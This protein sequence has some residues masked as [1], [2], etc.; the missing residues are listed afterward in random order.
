MKNLEFSDKN[1]IILYNRYIGDVKHIISTL[2][3]ED[4]DDIL[5]EINSHIYESMQ[6]NKSISEIDGIVETLDKLGNPYD[7]L[8]LLVA[9]R[10]LSQATKTFNPIHVFKALYLNISNGIMYVLFSLLYLVLFSFIFLIFAKI[11]Y[12]QKTG[13]FVGE[14]PIQFSFGIVD[15]TSTEILGNWFIP[16]VLILIV[17]IYLFITLLL[18]LRYKLKRKE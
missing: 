4:Q 15:N 13:L 3:K 17:V 9:D 1:A 11:I 2:P 16:V 12:P 10:K 6:R 14:N 18:K 7:S 5:M 8:S